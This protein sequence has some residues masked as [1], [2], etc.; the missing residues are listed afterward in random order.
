[1]VC[2]QPKYSSF[3]VLFLWY[4]VWLTLCFSFFGEGIIFHIPKGWFK[5]ICFL[6]SSLIKLFWNS[7]CFYQDFFDGGIYSKH[8]LLHHHGLKLSINNF[9]IFNPEMIIVYYEST[10][11]FL[12]TTLLMSVRNFL[13]SLA[14]FSYF[15]FSTIDFLEIY[16]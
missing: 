14:Y 7:L 13:H 11:I 8:H 12:L 2:Y 15:S 1:M 16:V 9:Y 6:S 10:V 3:L 5:I 4:N